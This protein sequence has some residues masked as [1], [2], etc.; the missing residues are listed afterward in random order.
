MF[1]SIYLR[2]Y[3]TFTDTTIDLSSNSTKVNNLILLYG[4]NGIG[5]SNFAS[6]FLRKRYDSRVY[7]KLSGIS[8]K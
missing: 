7:G 2:N 4:N 8:S 5:K 6:V 1:T 3:K